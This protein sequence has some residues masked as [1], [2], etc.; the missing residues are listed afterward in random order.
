[1]DDALVFPSGLAQRAGPRR[2]RGSRRARQVLAR[3]R[4][5]RWLARF[6]LY[7]ATVLS[8]LSVPPFGAMG[9]ALVTPLLALAALLGLAGGQMELHARRALAFALMLATL[10]LLQVLAVDSYSPASLLLLVVAHLP[11]VVQQRRAGGEDVLVLFQQLA[12]V[13]AVLGIAQYALQSTLGPALVFPMENYLPPDL[14]M[15]KYNTEAILRYGSEVRRANGVFMIEPSLFSQLMALGLVVEMLMRR[16][17][18][19]LGLLMAGL[20]VSY[21][22]TGIALLAACLVYEG[23][24]RRM[25]GAL[26]MAGLAGA[27]ALGLGVLLE[28]PMVTNLVARSAEFGISGSSGSMRFVAGFSLFEQWL[29]PD[30]YHAFFG[31]GAGSMASYANASPTPAAEMFLFKAVFE[32][33]ILGAGAYLAFIGYCLWAAA[34]PGVLRLAVLLVIAMGGLFTPFGHLFA[35]GLLLWPRRPVGEHRHG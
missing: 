1:M 30:P 4:W 31:Y 13:L 25:W 9:L 5:Q 24:A 19:W 26:L 2:L 22:G 12:L 20:L 16:R 33:G 8:K 21:S 34:A 10:V 14:T 18:L 6:P 29:W 15:A 23:V 3:R 28:V 17:L 35:C 7:G 32:Y 27:L 11:Y